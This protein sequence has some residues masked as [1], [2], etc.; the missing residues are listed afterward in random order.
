ML[1]IYS[2]LKNIEDYED[3]FP[4]PTYDQV[5]DLGITTEEVIYDYLTK[6]E[7][8]D[9]I[10]Y[11]FTSHFLSFVPKD[12]EMMNVGDDF[13]DFINNKFNAKFEVSLFDIMGYPFLNLA[14]PSSRIFIMD[15]IKFLH[16]DIP[17]MAEP[18]D[19]YYGEFADIFK[20]LGINI[21]SDIFK[22]FKKLKFLDE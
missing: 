3:V 20:N 21:I 2:E 14:L 7:L 10:K 6:R 17:Q 18:G 5:D 15:F 19:I 8:Y 22:E 13:F 9:C 1:S 11:L 16:K 12:S 4:I